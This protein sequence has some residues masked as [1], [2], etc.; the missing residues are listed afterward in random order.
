MSILSN[1]KYLGVRI[2]FSAG[3]L[4]VMAY[5]PEQEEAEEEIEVDYHGE[6]FEIGFNVSYLLDALNEVKTDDAE[7]YFTDSNH[8]CLICGVGDERS[9]YVVMPMR[10]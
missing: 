4:R 10:L 1:E 6:E 9:R 5:N 8:S 7:I 3:L 2:Q